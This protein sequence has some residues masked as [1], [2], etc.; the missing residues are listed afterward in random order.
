MGYDKALAKNGGV[1]AVEAAIKLMLKRFYTKHPKVM[2]GAAKIVVCTGNFHGRTITVVNASSKEHYKR[3]F[4]SNPGM[5]ISIPYN[6]ADALEDVLNSTPHVAGFLV[7]PIQG[8]GGVRV[9]DQG[10]LMRCFDICK[11]RDVV[12]CADEIQTGLGRTGTMLAS[13]HDGVRP[14]IVIMG[15]ALGLGRSAVSM[16]FAD[17]EYMCFE[18]GED[19]STYGGC[20]EAMV[21]AMTAFRILL[22]EYLCSNA[23][24]I[25]KLLLRYLKES[26]LRGDTKKLVKEIRG[27]GLMVGVELSDAVTA[28]AVVKALLTHGVV[29]MDANNTIRFTPP[30]TIDIWECRAL[31]K[32][33]KLAFQ[34]LVRPSVS[35]KRIKPLAVRA[36]LAAMTAGRIAPK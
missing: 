22:D 20:P 24:M 6:N 34:S 10:Y 35:K 16:V 1:E 29:T 7:E 9:P 23:E 4:I 5:Y 13:T 19:G 2:K 8:E 3:N 21:K 12:F 33:T 36:N 31:V 15:K 25:G 32:R 14:D 30:L 17:N 27:K 18:P 11:K 26:L 28:D